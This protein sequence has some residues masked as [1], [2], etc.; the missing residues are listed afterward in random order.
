MRLRAYTDFMSAASRIA[1]ARRS[2][3]PR[4]AVEDLAAL[5][6]AKTR[7]C[8]CASPSVVRSL[9]EFWERGGTLE[10]E[11]ELLAF[12]RFCKDMRADLGNSRNDLH[13]F[14]LPATLFRLSPSGYSFK[15]TPMNQSSNANGESDT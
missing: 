10:R 2:D 9:A 6:D 8:V 3:D 7:I 5:N 11:S 15:A 1:S 4:D 13:D 14:D 12:S